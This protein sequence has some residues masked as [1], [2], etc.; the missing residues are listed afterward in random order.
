MRAA[1]TQDYLWRFLSQNALELSSYKYYEDSWRQHYWRNHNAQQFMTKER[2][3]YRMAPIRHFKEVVKC[4]DSYNNYI[5][6]AD[7]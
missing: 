4:I 3:N 6:A 7:Y 1:A 5:F 2:F